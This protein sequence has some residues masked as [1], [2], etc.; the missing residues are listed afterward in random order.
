M[1]RLSGFQVFDLLLKC[2]R[3]QRWLKLPY[4]VVMA[5]PP[6]WFVQVRLLGYLKPGEVVSNRVLRTR[7]TG[8]RRQAE[9]RQLA[10]GWV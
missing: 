4:L 6:S 8:D 1:F 10:N 2:S 3:N 5:L 9:Y 7:Q